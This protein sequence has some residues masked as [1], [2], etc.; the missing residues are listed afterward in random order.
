MNAKHE[1]ELI[2]G[3]LARR[4][5]ER[6]AWLTKLRLVKFLY[7]LDLYWAQAHGGQTYTNWRWEFVH[8]GPYCRASTDSIDRAEK[9][10]YL[11]AKSY[12]SKYRDDDFRLYGPGPQ[13]HDD[14]ENQVRRQ[15]PTYVIGHLLPELDR[16]CDDTFGLLDFVYFR[17][18]P[19]RNALPGDVLSFENER[20][21]DRAAFRPIDLKPISKTK[22]AKLRELVSRI[23]S[24]EDLNKAQ[25][26]AAALFDQAYHDLS[27]M[28]DGDETPVGISGQADLEPDPKTDD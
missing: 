13:M 27:Q 16:W 7:L 8:Y 18:G 10:D 1:I 15:M 4:A 22:R 3:T 26:M 19:M 23:A 21:T 6:G 28:L 2:L 20:P 24:N 25:P 9:L 5:R 14:L 12:E 17:T 11:S